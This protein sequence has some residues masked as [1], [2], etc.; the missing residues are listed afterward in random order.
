MKPKDAIFISLKVYNAYKAGIPVHEINLELIEVKDPLS[1]DGL[2]P[3]WVTE[4]E[5]TYYHQIIETG[6]EFWDNEYDDLDFTYVSQKL[7]DD[8]RLS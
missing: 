8:W 3:A 7:F 1:S 6:A 2:L 4:Q 5:A